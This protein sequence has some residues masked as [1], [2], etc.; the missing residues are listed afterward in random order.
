MK[1]TAGL[2]IAR[3]LQTL[4][5]VARTGKHLSYSWNSLFSQ[6]IDAA[7]VRN[8]E[9]DPGCAERLEAFVSRFG[10]MQDTMADKLFPRWLLALA[11]TPGSQIETLNRAERLGVLSSTEQ[12]LEARNLSNRLVHEYITEPEKFAEDLALAKEYSL[13]LLDTY[14]RLRQD[15]IERMGQEAESLP[16]ALTLPRP[17]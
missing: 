3:F 2:P 14:N 9:Q 12:W 1:P 4:E 16:E 7:W 11:E 10:R 15:A 8:L 13:L 5:I 17:G 6:P